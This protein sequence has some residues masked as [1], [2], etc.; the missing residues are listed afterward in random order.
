MYTKMLGPIANTLIHVRYIEFDGNG[1]GNLGPVFYTRADGRKDMT[2]L[3]Y[4]FMA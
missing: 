3:V 1:P 4:D 2:K